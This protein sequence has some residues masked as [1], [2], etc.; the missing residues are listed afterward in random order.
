[1]YSNVTQE[2][3]NYY[4]N[5]ELILIQSVWATIVDSNH[6]IFYR[7]AVLIML[8]CTIVLY[9]AL[10]IC[11]MNV[12]INML[13]YY[14]SVPLGWFDGQTVIQQDNWSTYRL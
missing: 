12:C 6:N 13:V 14:L 10:C 1:M 9:A 8:R 5:T 4:M 11:C 7:I 3:P 2:H